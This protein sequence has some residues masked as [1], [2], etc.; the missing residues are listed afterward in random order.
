MNFRF[1]HCIRLPIEE[2]FRFHE[3]P[4]NLGV[5]LHGWP[6]F[7][8]LHHDGHIFPGAMTWF[9][10]TIAACIPMVLGFRHMLYE[11][12][13]RFAEELIHGPFR[14]FAHVHEF[15]QV[16]H[17]TMVRDLL[18]VRLP[19]HYGGDAAV[20]ICVAPALRRVFAFRHQALERWAAHAALDS[21]P[22]GLV[23]V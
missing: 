22:T 18:E 4:A 23:K 8:L 5:L 14:H 16:E 12:P 6:G 13:H 11:P 2:V 7:R 19:W 21:S 3:D 20:R 17:A 9:E 10:Q 1:E 15:E